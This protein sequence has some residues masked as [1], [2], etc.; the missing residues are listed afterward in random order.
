M[1]PPAQQSP[2]ADHQGVEATAHAEAAPLAA[3]ATTHV[4]APVTASEMYSAQPNVRPPGASPLMPSSDD[5]RQK[6]DQPFPS[7]FDRRSLRAA[8]EQTPGWLA[9]DDSDP[10][11]SSVEGDD[12]DEPVEAALPDGPPTI[13]PPVISSSGPQTVSTGGAI[14]FNPDFDVNPFR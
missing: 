2:Y 14:G 7:I 11:E 3:P 13:G 12:A 6:D 1:Q 9:P 8:S 10:D 5:R 4:D